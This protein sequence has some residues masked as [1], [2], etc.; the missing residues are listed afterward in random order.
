MDSGLAN[1]AGPKDYEAFANQVYSIDEALSCD[2]GIQRYSVGPE[3]F[4][5]LVVSN[6]EMSMAMAVGVWVIARAERFVRYT[7]DETLR[8]VADDIS[9]S[10]SRKMK[11]I[12][13]AYASRGSQ[14]HRAAVTQIVIPGNLELILL[15]KTEVDEEFPNIDLAKLTAEME[16][17]GDL[18]QE[19]ES[20]VFA[21]VGGDHWKLQYLTMRSGQVIGTRDCYNRTIEL[22]HGM[23]QSRPPKDVPPED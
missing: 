6:P 1:F 14:D 13:R 10:L 4:L 17:Y 19:A 21:R 15:V 7:V 16:K 20:A 23:G 18:L 12:L 9:D 2:K 8:K 22:L 11:A 3:P 5:Q